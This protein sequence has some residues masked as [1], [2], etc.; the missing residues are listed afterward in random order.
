MEINTLIAELCA[1][2][3]MALEKRA[4]LSEA[5]IEA[6]MIGFEWGCKTT[7]ARLLND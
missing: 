5:D 7:A 6:Y 1:A 3:R 2:E 4:Q